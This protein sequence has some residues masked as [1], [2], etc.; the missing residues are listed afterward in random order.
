M[1]AG[2]GEL[3]A[4]PLEEVAGGAADA[5]GG[6][7]GAETDFAAPFAVGDGPAEGDE[8]EEDEGEALEEVGG[9][10]VRGGEGGGEVGAEKEGGEEQEEEFG[11]EEELTPEP[12]EGVAGGWLAKGT[13]ASDGEGDEEDEGGGEGGAGE[14]IGKT[15]GDG[16]RA[17]VQGEAHEGGEEAETEELCEAEGGG[18]A[19]DAVPAFAAKPEGVA[20]EAGGEVGGGPGISPTSGGAE[21]GPGGPVAFMPELGLPGAAPVGAIG[22][23]NE[24][25]GQAEEGAV[26]FGKGAGWGWKIAG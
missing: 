19:Q 11:G 9:E 24:A 25:A 4:V 10:G 7:E 3:G 13:A 23:G 12:E 6:G 1:A 21:R 14:E 20:E 17:A 26:D 5:G 2:A 22:G 15:C 8:G 16:A 18:A